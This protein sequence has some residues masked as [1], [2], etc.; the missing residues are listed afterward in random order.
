M[1][2]ENNMR[3]RYRDTSL[4]CQ[5]W[6]RLWEYT[7]DG[8]YELW[9]S[10]GSHWMPAL[11]LLQAALPMLL[12]LTQCLLQCRHMTVHQAPECHCPVNISTNILSASQNLLVPNWTLD[13]GTLMKLLCFY[14]KW[15]NHSPNPRSHPWFLSF[16]SW[17][18]ISKITLFPHVLIFS[19]L[20]LN[21]SSMRVENYL[22]T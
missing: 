22:L 9:I 13:F 8:L 15:H 16:T 7:R 14:I 10:P 1:Y 18:W 19:L 2:S 21:F 4:I 12:P 11:F 17:R 5:Y 3:T 6:T 20:L